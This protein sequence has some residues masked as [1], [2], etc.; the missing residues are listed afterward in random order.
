MTTPSVALPD[1]VELL[2]SSDRV[3]GGVY[4]CIRRGLVFSVKT[5]LTNVGKVLRAGLLASPVVAIS[6]VP[7]LGRDELNVSPSEAR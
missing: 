6:Q 4:K 1:L 2:V 5:V 3:S 7:L